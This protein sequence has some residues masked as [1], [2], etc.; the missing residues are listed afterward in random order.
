[1]SLLVFL[2]HVLDFEFDIESNNK[3]HLWL[4]IRL[5]SRKFR[6]PP[7]HASLN[8]TFRNLRQIFVNTKKLRGETKHIHLDQK[9]ISKLKKLFFT[10]INNIL[11][12]F[13]C[14][15]IIWYIY[16][17]DKRFREFI[18]SRFGDLFWNSGTSFSAVISIP[19]TSFLTSRGRKNWP[20][21]WVKLIK[22]SQALYGTAQEALFRVLV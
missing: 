1:M 22:L 17:I 7:F 20:K 9:K 13:K 14:L 15:N 21:W 12:I 5:D 16:F 6:I 19:L 10:Y 3:S 18:K 4:Q 11:W 8:F 2:C